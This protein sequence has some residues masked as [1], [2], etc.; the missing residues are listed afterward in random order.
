MWCA[1][2]LLDAAD[3]GSPRRAAVDQLE[4][5]SPFSSFFFV[6]ELRSLT[7]IECVRVCVPLF[8]AVIP[9]GLSGI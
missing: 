7:T 1:L 8:H 3:D 9:R 6:L 5:H 4:F 2:L